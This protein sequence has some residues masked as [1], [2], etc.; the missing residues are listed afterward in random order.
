MVNNVLNMP[1]YVQL[2]HVIVYTADTCQ[3]VCFV[4][5]AGTIETMPTS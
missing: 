2:L 5:Q 1:L 4:Q 3:F